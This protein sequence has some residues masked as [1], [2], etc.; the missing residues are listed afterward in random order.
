MRKTGVEN[1][2]QCVVNMSLSQPGKLFLTVC[3]EMP[4]LF[5][6]EA[7]DYIIVLVIPAIGPN[8]YKKCGSL[9][10]HTIYLAKFE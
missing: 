3:Y 10:R 5:A 8:K 7:W 1:K 6:V 9:R 4:A 2:V